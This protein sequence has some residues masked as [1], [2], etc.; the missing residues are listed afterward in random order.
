[1][2]ASR[3]GHEGCVRLLLE[4]EAIEVNAKGVSLERALSQAHVMVGFD[5]VT[6]FVSCLLSSE[7]RI[8][9]FASRGTLGLPRDRQA[10][11]RT[12]RRSDAPRQ[13]R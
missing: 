3:N 1:M 2:L 7:L 13:G 12:R 4:S 10:S 5:V 9:S 8:V 11:P 6:S